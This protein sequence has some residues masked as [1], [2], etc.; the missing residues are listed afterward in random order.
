MT[1]AESHEI[2]GL[3]RSRIREQVAWV[4]DVLVH[5]RT[6]RTSQNV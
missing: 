3:V 2:A 6:C 5:V 4:A 1:V